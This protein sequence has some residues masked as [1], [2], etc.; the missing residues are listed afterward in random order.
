MATL[1]GIAAC[2]RF[3]GGFY[4]IIVRDRFERHSGKPRRADAGTGYA[5]MEHCM[6][7]QH[8]G[9]MLW[10]LFFFV[11]SMIPYCFVLEK[12]M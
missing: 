6:F 12:I 9:L 11:K 3:V 2:S 5:P 1:L 8:G 4:S 10:T 7:S